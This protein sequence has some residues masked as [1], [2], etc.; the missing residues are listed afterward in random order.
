M[1]TFGI[2]T[3][4]LPKGGKIKFKMVKLPPLEGVTLTFTPI[5]PTNPDVLHLN[6]RNYRKNIFTIP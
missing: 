3:A 4:Y 6:I 5:N 1:I 2:N